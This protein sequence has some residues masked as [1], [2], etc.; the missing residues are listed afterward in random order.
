[1]KTL[2]RWLVLTLAVLAAGCSAGNGSGNDTGN[3]GGDGA[4]HDGDATVQSDVAMDGPIGSDVVG[5]DVPPDNR[6]T[7][8]MGMGPPVMVGDSDA[9][10]PAGTCAGSIAARIFNH[11][12]C[13][14]TSANVA[15]YFKTQSFASGMGGM[16]ISEGAP[17]GLDQTYTS[18]SYTDVGG[19]FDIAGTTN[20]HFAGYLRVGGDLMM[21]SGLDVAGYINVH[22]D[23]WLNGNTTA[24]GLIQIGRDLHLTPGHTAPLIATIGGRTI[25]APFTIDPPCDCAAPD[26]LDIAGIVANAQ[27]SNDNAS[28]GLDPASLSNV[29]G[30]G[31]D[32]TLPCG[33]FYVNSVGGLGAITVH[34]PGRTALFV[35]GD[36]NAIGAFNV[37]MGPTGELDLFIA[38]DLLSIGAGSFGNQSRPAATRIYVG[39]TGDVTL[40]GA[41]GFVGNVY[42][43]RSRITAI[44]GTTVYGSVFGRLIDMPGYFEV[45]YDRSILDV[46][47]DCPPPPGMCSQCSGTCAG[48]H[49]CVGGMCTGCHT[50]GDCCAPLVCYPD[51]TCQPL[52]G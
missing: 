34:V 7:Y 51:G 29:A 20:V 3:G 14:C 39:G 5:A 19:T 48:H 46:G 32:I 42:A 10:V 45:H 26:L 47:A 27:T 23:T 1:M 24:L 13:S 49:A 28:V 36:V 35:G 52:I 8:C 30:I 22:R 21:G 33:R 43:P 2:G 6:M 4:T 44:G 16:L 37:M 17:V 11:S 12:V 18:G 15:G 40:V 38:G 31:V 9:G 41:S 50:D 25:T